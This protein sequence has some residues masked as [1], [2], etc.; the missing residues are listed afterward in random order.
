MVSLWCNTFLTIKLS[1][2]LF[3]HHEDETKWQLDKRN[4]FQKGTIKPLQPTGLTLKHKLLSDSLKRF[5][6][7]FPATYLILYIFL[8]LGYNTHMVGK[9]HLG[10]CRSAYLPT[11]RCANLSTNECP[12]E[13]PPPSEA[14]IASPGT[15]QAQ[16]TTSATYGTRATTSGR[17]RTW[18]LGH[19]A[20]TQLICSTKKR[21]SDLSIQLIQHKTWSGQNCGEGDGRSAIFSLLGLSGV[22]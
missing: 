22:C 15:T 18:T 11:R 3:P 19:E 7:N 20:T 16:S 10:F 8:S 2:T 12:P 14:S 9:W 13:Q 17:T 21:Y 5:S 1:L 4:Y 6:L